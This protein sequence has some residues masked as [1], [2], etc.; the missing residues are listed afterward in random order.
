MSQ[1]SK[2]S[3]Y[4][5]LIKLRF[6]EPKAFSIIVSV[7][8]A[9]LTYLNPEAL[10][11]IYRFTRE[12]SQ[13]NG[14]IMEAGCALGG[15]AIV[16]GAAKNDDT[17]LAVYDVFGQI[18][19]PKE[20]MDGDDAIRRFEVIEAGA[21]KGVGE[22]KYYGYQEDL[23]A[24]VQA[25]FADHGQDPGGI[26]FVQGLYEDTMYPERPIALAHI[27]CDWYESVW[28]CLNRITPKLVIGGRMI[29]DDYDHWS[30]CKKAIDEFMEQNA[31]TYEMQSHDRVHLVRKA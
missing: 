10:W 5:F 20:G 15:S 7:I 16:M 17:R 3:Q 18:P 11:D 25:S 21:S 26:D 29:I 19:P 24:K 2:L 4:L 14:D 8:R 27:D 12:A 31:S 23:L 6:R 28:T 22:D 13:M 30:G 9:K 1:R